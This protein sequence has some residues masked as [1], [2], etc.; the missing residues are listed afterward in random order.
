M[1]GNRAQ[2][3]S[4]APSQFLESE[5]QAGG[6]G[7]GKHEPGDTHREAELGVGLCREERPGEIR[8]QG[9]M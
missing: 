1:L 6:G 9:V 3:R 4:L 5:E 7:C 2:P 8:Q